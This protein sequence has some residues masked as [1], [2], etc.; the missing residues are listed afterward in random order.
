MLQKRGTLICVARFPGRR[1]CAKPKPLCTIFGRT[2]A[3]H[4]TPNATPLRFG[5][6]DASRLTAIHLVPTDITDD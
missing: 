2:N 1:G 5:L 4:S 6:G 3:G